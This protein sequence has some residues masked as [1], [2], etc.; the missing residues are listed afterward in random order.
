MIA[1][2]QI[3]DLALIDEDE[4]ILVINEDGTFTSGPRDSFD[5]LCGP[6]EKHDWPKEGF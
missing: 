2:P 5:F 3:N 1:L 6:K 4:Y